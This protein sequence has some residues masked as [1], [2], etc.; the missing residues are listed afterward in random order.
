MSVDCGLEISWRESTYR[1]RLRG[2][3]FTLPGPQAGGPV[4]GDRR[5][6][7]ALIC[8]KAPSDLKRPPTRTGGC[9]GVDLRAT[10]L[11]LL[12]LG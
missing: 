3:G 2:H 6:D 8:I 10:V 11:F 4:T 12:R 7:L 1:R 9:V 5:M